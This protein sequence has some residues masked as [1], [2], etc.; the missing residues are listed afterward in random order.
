MPSTL[1]H[2]LL[3]AAV[4]HLGWRLSVA[5]VAA[6]VAAK[7]GHVKRAAIFERS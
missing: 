3:F 5:Q 1:R 6:Q 4:V 2:S 7:C